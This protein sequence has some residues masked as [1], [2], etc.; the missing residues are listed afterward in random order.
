MSVR[1]RTAGNSCEQCRA[2][3][4]FAEAGYGQVRLGRR[5]YSTNR[6]QANSGG[7]ATAAAQAVL[8]ALLERFT[9]RTMGRLHR[10]A[11]GFA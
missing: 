9:H 8:D 5:L 7:A 10:D 6:Y 2:R 4:N 3:L 1:G 11:F